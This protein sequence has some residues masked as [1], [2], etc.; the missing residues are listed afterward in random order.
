[1]KTNPMNKAC[2]DYR[3]AMLDALED[4][5]D[6][7]STVSFEAHLADCSGCEAEYASLN[8]TLRLLDHD[9]RPAGT[10]TSMIDLR[11]RVCVALAE[12]EPRRS[13]PMRPAWGLAAV[14]LLI[15]LFWWGGPEPV[16]EGEKMLAQVEQAGR[17]SLD[18]GLDMSPVLLEQVLAEDFPLDDNLDDMIDELSSVELE[19]LSRRLAALTVSGAERDPS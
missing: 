2:R 14:L 5:L 8:Q 18:G 7:E 16:H 13:L 10:D 15:A 11:R 9:V 12:D 17:A 19:A 3:G 4:R 6:A 1:M